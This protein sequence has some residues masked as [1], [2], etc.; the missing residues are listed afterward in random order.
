MTPPG[1]WSV[2]L[3]M[4]TCASPDC[5]SRPEDVVRVARERGLDRIAVTDHDEI[6]GAFAARRLDPEL[7]IVGEEV[8]TAEGPDLIG[9]FLTEHIP[10]GTPF[11]TV[12][13]T[14]REQGGVVYLPHPFDPYRGVQ[15]EMLR[16]VAGC[17]DLVEGF[18]SRVHGPARNQ[19]AVSWARE[20]DLPVGAGS[21]AHLLREIG[22]GRLVLPP[23]RDPREF[24]ESAGRGRIE[25]EPSSRLVHLGSTWAKVR[26]FLPV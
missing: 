7:V 5:L 26:N 23:F 14:I 11:R 16:T 15:Q 21:D 24:L 25:G 17:V 3:H 4:H 20:R 2:D 8:R 1:L 13:R 10:G 12:A 9:L 22:R 19:R 6:R 18:N